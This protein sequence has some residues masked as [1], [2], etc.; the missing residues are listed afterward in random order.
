[1]TQE[2][3]DLLDEI[4]YFIEKNEH[5]KLVA[6]KGFNLVKK[7]KSE[8]GIND[9]K[10]SVRY[11][12]IDINKFSINTLHMQTKKVLMRLDITNGTH[13]NPDGTL[14]RGSHIHILQDGTEK[15]AYPIDSDKYQKIFP[16]KKD[17]VKLFKAYLE[18]I[19]IVYDGIIFEE[20]T[21][22]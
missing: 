17:R 4:K 16:N 22:L 11:G 15:I 13:T 21:F 2:E 19:N 8:S 7:I 1:M 10:L 20:T 18:L 5:I 3:K 6:K 12:K 14:I 9:Y